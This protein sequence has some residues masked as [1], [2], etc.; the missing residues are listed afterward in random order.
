MIKQTA[1]E[2]ETDFRLS[3]LATPFIFGA[4]VTGKS[5]IQ[6]NTPCQDANAFDILPS[7][8]CIIAIADGLGS[9]KRSDI[10]A[11]IAVKTAIE[12]GKSIITEKKDENINYE[13]VL[14]EIVTSSRDALEVQAIK[15]K[16]NLRDL[17]CT[18]IIV[19]FSEDNIFVA[20]IGDGAVV[21]KIEGESILISEPEETEYINEV[22]PLTSKKWDESLRITSKISNIECVA[23]FTD[24]CQWSSLLKT[25]NVWQPYERFFSPLF[26]YAQELEHLEQ[27]ESEIKDLLSSKK[28]S[29]TSEDDKTLLILVAK[30]KR[31]GNG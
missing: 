23:V 20:H 4:S 22:V 19:L 3:S 28:L 15:E 9:A 21:A 14:K 17:A 27:G 25:Q 1:E 10:G 24:G 13:K 2:A 16:C 26:E 8:E 6:F 31:T 5:H 18:L 12:T 30:R 7:G 29:E 11:K